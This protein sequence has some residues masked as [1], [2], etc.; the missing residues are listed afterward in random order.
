MCVLAV[1]IDM[2][3]TVKPTRDVHLAAV[4]LTKHAEHQP[5]DVKHIKHV[6]I[7]KKQKSQ[8]NETS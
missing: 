4:R 1:H 3:I 8:E 6:G 2:L 5:V 7:I